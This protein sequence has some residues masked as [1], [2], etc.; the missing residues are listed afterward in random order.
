MERRTFIKLSGLTTFG[1]LAGGNLIASAFNMKNYQLVEIN[2][3]NIHV[4]HGF[5]NLQTANQNRLAVQRDIFNQNGLEEISEY[6]MVSIKI[7]EGHKESF[8]ITNKNG[9][10]SK[11]NRLSAIQLK[12]NGSKSINVDSPSLIFAEFNRLTINGVLVENNQAFIQYSKK[13]LEI[14]SESNQ[15]VFIY[16]IYNQ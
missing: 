15:S 10:K 6:R 1:L 8:G 12:A 9:F 5:F 13:E 4:R 7:S 3:P 16:K 14:K 11:S 2:L